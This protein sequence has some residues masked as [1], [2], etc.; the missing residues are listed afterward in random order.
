MIPDSILLV[1]DDEA[2]SA[3][4]ARHLRARGYTVH[5]AGS[6]EAARQILGTGVRPSAVILDINLPGETGWSLLRDRTALAA[7]GDPPVLIAS[8]TAISPRRLEEYGVAGYL[9]KPFPLETLLSTLERL[10]RLEE[11][12]S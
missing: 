8:A 1:E 3:I 6:T 4:L 10:I 12:G 11:V 9:P 5:E 2:L 7:A